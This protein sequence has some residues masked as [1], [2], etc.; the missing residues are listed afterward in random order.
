MTDLGGG[1]KNKILFILLLDRIAAEAERLFTNPLTQAY[2]CWL[3]TGAVWLLSSEPCG[4]AGA[5]KERC[6]ANA[7][8]GDRWFAVWVLHFEAVF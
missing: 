1:V 8:C 6:W 3:Y 7:V 4:P 2:T 5:L